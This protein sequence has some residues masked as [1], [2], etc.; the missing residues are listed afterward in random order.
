MPVNP[1]PGY[2]TWTSS[3]Y[4]VGSGSFSATPITGIADTGTTLVYLPTAVVT[5][6]YRQVA[7]ATNSRYYGGYVF[8][9]DSA[10]P[11]FTFG[12]G[13][14]RFTIPPSYINYTRVTPTS[15]TCFGGLQSSSAVGI[16]IWGDVALK[17]AFVVFNGANPPTLG[18]AEKPLVK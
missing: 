9:C 17:A 2:W 4:A 11:S 12:V 5:S 13:S 3:G 16:N 14:A 1:D 18:W 15:T 7:G 8:P 10:L 6:Y